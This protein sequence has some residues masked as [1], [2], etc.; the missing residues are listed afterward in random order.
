MPG[1]NHNPEKD[2]WATLK[3]YLK[4]LGYPHRQ[5]LSKNG[6]VVRDLIKSGKTINDFTKMVET[7]LIKKQWTRDKAPK[8][9]DRPSSSKE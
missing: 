6:D 1:G 7:G 3:C 5:L 4:Y 9:W 2:A 8:G